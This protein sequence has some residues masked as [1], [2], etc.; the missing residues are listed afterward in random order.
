MA[1]FEPQTVAHLERLIPPVGYPKNP[2]D[3][4][5]LIFDQEKFHQAIDL[6]AADPGTESLL[7]QYANQSTTQI[8]ADINFLRTLRRTSNKPIALSFIG[9]EI[10]YGLR[11]RL[12]RSGLLYA[13]DPDSAVRL[14]SWLLVDRDV[15]SNIGTASQT[16]SS[17]WPGRWPRTWREGTNFLE[18]CGIDTVPWA[19]VKPND[20]I[21][22]AVSHLRFPVVVKALPEDAPHKSEL[23][24]VRLD[25]RDRLE[26]IGAAADIRARLGGEHSVLVQ[27]MVGASTEALI[28]VRW[29]KDF[30]P[31]VAIG[32]GGVGVEL[33]D[34]VCYLALP[35]SEAEIL[36]SVARLRL[37]AL[38]DGFRG[39][40]PRDMEALVKA[41]FALGNAFAESGSV[42]QEIEINPFCVLPRGQGGV[43][44]DMLFVS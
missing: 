35:T 26:L 16:A 31:I 19:I 29:D 11:R 4:D 8:R 22:G 14:L 40:E 30:G 24:L 21:Q 12:I 5:G 7:V 36:R 34:D 10:D 39:A 37:A 17:N 20:D 38:L 18:A 43:A 23:G 27:E 41:A 42:G 44:I 3:V 6:I 2:V 1:V 28:S 9:R 33:F 13:A 25:V 15:P 32:M